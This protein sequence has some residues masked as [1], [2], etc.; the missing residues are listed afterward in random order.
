MQNETLP[1][2]RESQTNTILAAL[3]A[4][5]KLTPLDALKELGCFRL[6]ARIWDIRKMGYDIK[7]EMV[8]LPNGKR[9]AS[10]F[11]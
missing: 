1:F 2:N 11:L 9:I 5:R 6:G 4:G 10:Y 7:R 3:L 8:E